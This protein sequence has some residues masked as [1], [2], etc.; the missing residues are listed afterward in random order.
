M[1]PQSRGGVCNAFGNQRVLILRLHHAAS[2][3][4]QFKDRLKHGSLQFGRRRVFAALRQHAVFGNVDGRRRNVVGAAN[5]TAPWPTTTTTTRPPRRRPH[6]HRDAA[7]TRPPRRPATCRDG[8]RPTPLRRT[9]CRSSR[10][11][12]SA[13]SAP[14]AAH[15]ARSE[16]HPAADQ[17]AKRQQQ[18][19]QH[20]QCQ[21]SVFVHPH[22]QNYFMRSFFNVIIT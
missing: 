14:S 13:A 5:A 17:S 12:A 21:R 7:S 3:F 6:A 22:N 19:C 8:E 18:T 16:S 15:R 11:P 20:G 1:S 10:A 9:R 4:S 2:I